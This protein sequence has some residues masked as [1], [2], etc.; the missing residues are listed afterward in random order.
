M[1]LL[2][3]NVYLPKV[4]LQKFV[5]GPKSFNLNKYNTLMYYMYFMIQPT[6][7][8]RKSHRP[9]WVSSAAC[10]TINTTHRVFTDPY[11]REKESREAQQSENRGYARGCAKYFE[12]TRSIGWWYQTP[13]FQIIIFQMITSLH[14][15]YSTHNTYMEWK[16]KIYL[17]LFSTHTIYPHHC[18]P[19]STHQSMSFFITNMRKT[20]GFKSPAS[21][22]TRQVSTN[23]CPSP[24]GQLDS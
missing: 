5:T 23:T 19:P 7:I 17:Q 14:E 20:S 11:V 9:V 10:N 21:L 2:T 6:I 18:F 3:K 12:N 4:T 24:Y 13:L 16:R 15:G 1:E 22:L 8:F